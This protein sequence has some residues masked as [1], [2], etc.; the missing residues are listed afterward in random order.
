[1]KSGKEGK[2]G[3]VKNQEQAIAIRI[4]ESRQAGLKVPKEEN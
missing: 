4:S 2:S 1:M 3:I